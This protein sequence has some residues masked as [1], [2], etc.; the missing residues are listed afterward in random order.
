MQIKQRT[1]QK[2]AALAGGA[3]KVFVRYVLFTLN[4]FAGI[5]SK[6]R[7]IFVRRSKY[8]HK[9]AEAVRHT[10][11]CRCPPLL[12]PSRVVFVSRMIP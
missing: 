6:P 9:K 10:A 2:S 8:K 12:R 5:R 3:P 1:T 7:G 11:H 4:N